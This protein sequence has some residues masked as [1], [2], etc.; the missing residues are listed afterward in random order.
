[1]KKPLA[2]A[3]LALTLSASVNAEGLFQKGLEAYNQKDYAATIE[4][5]R[6][7]AESG[8]VLA[9]FNLGVMYANG[10]GVPKDDAQAVVW[11]HKAAKQGNPLAQLNLGIMYA[12]GR[13]V[14]QSFAQA[15]YWQA[16]S[17]QQDNQTAITNLIKDR[18]HLLMY[19]VKNHTINI[20]SEPTTKST[21]I[22]QAHQGQR[23][24]QLGV[25]SNG[26]LEVYLL[27]GYTVGYVSESV[28]ERVGAVTPRNKTSNKKP[29]TN[30]NRL[31]DEAMK[32]L[33]SDPNRGVKLMQE[34]ADAGHP[35]AQFN[36]GLFYQQG[37]YLRK[38]DSSA[39]QWYEKAARQGLSEAQ[40]NLG[41]LYEHKFGNYLEASKWYRLAAD[42]NNAYGMHN[43]GALYSCGWGVP[44]DLY[45]AEYY[46]NRSA[47]AG[48]RESYDMLAGIRSGAQCYQTAPNYH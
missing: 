18:E 26:W 37:H 41:L 31:F 21:V 23:L 42:Q 20:R 4:I 16:L 8:D 11:Y 22:K 19:R 14:G 39:A 15:V 43:L 6:P 47:A 38:D 9:Q 29:A 10:E 13:G 17:A 30:A 48:I 33:V 35:R 46:L 1:M 44:R 7:L 45:K 36:V 3:L 32:T 12:H 24:Y 34:A 27:H 2:T 5:W 28:V 25:P 40:V